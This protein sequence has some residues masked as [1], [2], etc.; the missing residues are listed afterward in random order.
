M[1]K[2]KAAIFRIWRRLPTFPMPESSINAG[3]RDAK[4]VY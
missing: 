4:P 3:D 2:F 1:T